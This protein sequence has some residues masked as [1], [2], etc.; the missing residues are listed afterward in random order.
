VTRFVA[1][2]QK[3]DVDDLIKKLWTFCT[4]VIYKNSERKYFC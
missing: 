1:S 4:N 3:P 2:G